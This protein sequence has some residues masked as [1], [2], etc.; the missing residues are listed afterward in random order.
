MS[1]SRASESHADLL[2]RIFDLRVEASTVRGELLNLIGQVCDAR[3]GISDCLRL[4]LV[5]SLAPA[6]LH[7][8][9]N[10]LG[11]IND[12]SHWA[13][14]GAWASSRPSCTPRGRPAVVV[15]QAASVKVLLLDEVEGPGKQIVGTLQVVDARESWSEQLL[16]TRRSW[17]WRVCR[18]KLASD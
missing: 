9:I 11:Y 8:Y 4:L 13:I 2:L 7:S 18:K 12:L 15:L 5:I 16:A 14:L 3:V 10:D 6:C 17:W 1:P